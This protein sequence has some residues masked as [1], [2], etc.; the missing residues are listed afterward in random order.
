MTTYEKTHP[1]LSFSLD[2][3]K[4]DYLL[5]LALG[6]ARSKSEHIAGV[7]LRPAT[8]EKL[9]SIYLAKGAMATTAIEG[10]TLSEEEVLARVEGKLKLPPSKEHLG[11]EID[12]II[13]ACNEISNKLFTGEQINLDTESIKRFNQLVLKNLPHDDDVNPGK[14]RGHKVGVG[15]YLAAP[16]E[17]CEVLLNKLCEWLNEKFEAPEGLEMVFGILKAIVA[18]LY[19]VW[20]HPF[21]DGNGRTARLVEFQILISSGVPSAAAHLLSNHYNLTRQAYYRQLDYA[22]K[23]QVGII[24]FIQYAIQGF[25]DGLQEQI[26][27]IRTQQWDVT[28]R[29]Y[30]H[31]MFKDKTTAADHRR[32]HLVLDL[33]AKDTP[34]PLNQIRLISTRLAEA[35][36]TKKSKTIARDINELITMDLIEKTPEGIRAR[37]EKILAFLPARING[38]Q[39]Q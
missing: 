30:V 4:S 8:A 38:D 14:I 7:P 26:E 37:R 22:R 12:N 2:L 28:W 6:E 9:H 27:L 5:W 19:L 31:E 3:H 39:A 33:S 18:H 35:Y 34:I 36:A 11:Q 13:E 17:D 24:S 29:N 16:P 23:P 1:W 21:G 25:V 15:R 32:R 10:N 20:I